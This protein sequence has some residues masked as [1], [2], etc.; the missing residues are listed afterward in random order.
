MGCFG[1]PSGG[2][3]TIIEPE[4][5]ADSNDSGYPEYISLI[6]GH[7]LY[8]ETLDGIRFGHFGIT[9]YAQYAD[10]LD[11]ITLRAPL[12][13][14]S[15]FNPPTS[16]W[17][18]ALNIPD[19]VT[20]T[21][22]YL[23]YGDDQLYESA[24]V[25]YHIMP[26]ATSN[27]I[28]DR[29][30]PMVP[31]RNWEFLGT[32]PNWDPSLGYY[33][34][35]QWD[36]DNLTNPNDQNDQLYTGGTIVGI[37]RLPYYFNTP[38]N[39]HPHIINAASDFQNSLKN[40]LW[41]RGGSQVS[42]PK[43]AIQV[44]QDSEGNDILHISCK[45]FSENDN[46]ET[47]W[48]KYSPALLEA[49]MGH[50][51]SFSLH[52]ITS[53]GPGPTNHE[54]DGSN[55]HCTTHTI[56][57]DD[58]LSF[59]IDQENLMNTSLKGENY[60][61]SEANG[62]NLEG[63]FFVITGT[64]NII[65]SKL[66]ATSNP[67]LMIS[68][69]PD[70]DE[71]YTGRS[72]IASEDIPEWLGL[73]GSL[74]VDAPNMNNWASNSEEMSP[75][76][77]NTLPDPSTNSSQ[78]RTR[79]Y[80]GEGHTRP[81]TISYTPDPLGVPIIEGG[82]KA[83]IVADNKRVEDAFDQPT[84][85]VSGSTQIKPQNMIGLNISEFNGSVTYLDFYEDSGYIEGLIG[86]NN[87][88]ELKTF[89]ASEVVATSGV[90]EVL[91]SFIDIQL[92]SPDTVDGDEETNFEG[93][94]TDKYNVEYKYSLIYDN[95]QETPLSLHSTMFDSKQ[96]ADAFKIRVEIHFNATT[97]SDRVTEIVI[98]RRYV[99]QFGSGDTSFR[100]VDSKILRPLTKFAQDDNGLRYYSFNDFNDSGPVYE[101]LTGMPETLTTFSICY[102]ISESLDG[103]LFV[104][105]AQPYGL[106]E[107]FSNYIFRSKSAKY[108]IFNPSDNVKLPDTII[109]LKAWGGRMYAFTRKGMYRINQETLQ[110]E[111][112]YPGVLAYSADS[113][114]SNEYGLFIV[115][116]DNIYQF[117]G[118]GVTVIS[119]AISRSKESV[120]T[121]I[122][123]PYYEPSIAGQ[124]NI[125]SGLVVP[126][127]NGWQDMEY[128]N[129]VVS[130][131]IKRKSLLV[132][133]SHTESSGGGG[134]GVDGFC[135]SYNLPRKRWDL[136]TSPGRV[137]SVYTIN[138]SDIVVATDLGAYLFLYE[139]SD[140][141][142]TIARKTWTWLSKFIGFSNQSQDK[143]LKNIKVMSNGKLDN[144][145]D[146]TG[147]SLT[148]SYNGDS[149][150]SLEKEPVH[151][152]D[153]F[154]DGKEHIYITK[155]TP[156]TTEGKRKFKELL[157]GLNT[158]K[159][160]RKVSSVSAVYTAKK[161]K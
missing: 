104:A 60:I 3:G 102:S 155:A 106:S 138:N 67:Y 65:T 42:Y 59:P 145:A 61:F 144:P 131:D 28:D 130:F 120:R 15:D 153:N 135:W 83:L 41:F 96:A 76:E 127:C 88:F 46:I 56:T 69:S 30:G 2:G 75:Y 129:I 86:S 49:G 14:I 140:S 125:T 37:S 80:Y 33:R 79:D 114:Y 1:G 92:N 101:S 159:G 134:D 50:S 54:L 16:Y 161:V 10:S 156:D 66:I 132:F 85:V 5:D 20:G 72:F 58:F 139:A 93:S 151:N 43:K 40:R 25:Q 39:P 22:E 115:G 36:G 141:S 32:G 7:G 31:Q 38:D 122:P 23:K 99:K 84:G 18:D 146:M 98:Y 77:P 81:F 97:F 52:G 113:I 6:Y 157:I 17:R 73:Q 108:S 100:M 53:H 44:S 149:T 147:E 24:L 45:P 51:E 154:N 160:T 126:S 70:D 121:Q 74:E 35:G 143:K 19:T 128:H 123:G 158:I 95:N 133:F 62:K 48:L 136:L 105:A 21:E 4:W 148:V 150:I 26:D 116:Q 47:E 110:V 142:V 152:I 89:A 64:R 107:D 119:E 109:G 137:R 8:L 124:M 63:K 87:S 91:G 111:D 29:V 90:I 13:T 9:R 12:H 103:W 94:A 82:I 27:Y 78:I 11:K 34:I 57:E 68:R 55:F 117:Q 118:Q 112:T 71:I